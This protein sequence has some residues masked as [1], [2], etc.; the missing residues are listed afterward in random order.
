MMHVLVL[1]GG[2]IGTASAWYLA[3]AGFEVTVVER[4]RAAALETS[5]ANAGQLSF[6]YV[7]PWAAP[8]IPLKALKWLFQRH[9][10]LAIAPGLDPAQY[11]FMWQMLRNCTAERYAVNKARMVRMCE[12]SRIALRELR[13]ETGIEYE[14]RRRGTLQ[15]FRTQA[16][17]DAVARDLPVLEQYGVPYEVLDE[18]G[19]ARSEPALAASPVRFMGALRTPND[20]TGDCHLFTQRLARLAAHIGVQ[21]RC[22]QHIERLERDG[23]RI[24]GVRVDGELVRADRYVLAL[25]SYSTLLMAPLGLR[26]PVYPLKGYSLTL[27]VTDAAMAPVSTVLDESYKVAITRFDNRIRVGGMAE[28]NGYD[29]SLPPQRR[30]TLEK[31]VQQ[32]YPRGGDLKSA[33][34]WCGLR[35]ATPDGTPVV[36][37][38]PLRNLYTNTG[39][40]TLGWTMACGSARYLAELINGQQAG[41]SSEGLDMSRYVRASR[42]MAMPTVVP[43]SAPAS[44]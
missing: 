12:Y 14:G 38:T 6:G 19:V 9:S 13:A 31:V 39:H 24:T 26:L 33:E 41:I 37:A 29:L 28:L 4:Q 22:G 30:H 44:H 43:S 16:Q 27:P 40:G 18:E 32:L 25:G 21:F 8:G 20:E 35:P 10:P 34:F 5:Y 7:S 36:G 3:R 42:S 1:G 2:V 17:L 15:L 23:D 11:R